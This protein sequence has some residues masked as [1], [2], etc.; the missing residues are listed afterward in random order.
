VLI[1]CSKEGPDARFAPAFGSAFLFALAL[2]VRPN[3]APGAAVLL[4]G[5][6]IA[7]LWQGEFRRLAGLCIGFAPVFSMALHNWV[8][9][10]VFVLFSA[11]ATIAEALPMPPSAYVAAFG[12]LLRLDFGSE[13][14]RNGI[15]QIARWLAGPSESFIMIPLHALAIVVLLRVGFAR[16][17]DPWLRL[18]AWSALALHPVALFYLSYDRY[19]YLM[20]FL[21]LLVSAA[22]MHDEGFGLLRRW[23]PRLANMIADHPARAGWA[24]VLEAIEP[25]PRG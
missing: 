14:V 5:A 3:L 21:T 16:H 10:G 11:N 7:A 13:H 22:W 15:V 20:W 12:E 25:E 2:F 4:G 24:R 1:G 9:G 17:F 19:Y 6:G 23:S 8:F 18:T